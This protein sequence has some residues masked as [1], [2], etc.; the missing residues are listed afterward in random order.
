MDNGLDGLSEKSN[1]LLTVCCSLSSQ[2]Q[3]NAVLCRLYAFSYCTSLTPPVSGSASALPQHA[4]STS[5]DADESGSVSPRGYA[6][7]FKSGLRGSARTCRPPRAP[8]GSAAPRDVRSTT[9]TCSQARGNRRH[10]ASQQNTTAVLLED[11]P[12]ANNLPMLQA[13]KATAI[14][15]TRGCAYKTK[16]CLHVLPRG[17]QG[18][19]QGDGMQINS[20][21]LEHCSCSGYCWL[22]LPLAA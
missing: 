4:A 14:K 3:Q 19:I 17:V 21:N 5:S 11:S 20:C 1:S 13:K 7:C 15:E 9:T 12:A 6:A 8:A 22:T 2:L 10:Q 16:V 18:T